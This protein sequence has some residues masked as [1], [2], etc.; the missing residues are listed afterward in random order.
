MNIAYNKL[1]LASSQKCFH[2]EEINQNNDPYFSSSRGSEARTA[3]ALSPLI[4]IRA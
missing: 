4:F 3:A 2:T 1:I